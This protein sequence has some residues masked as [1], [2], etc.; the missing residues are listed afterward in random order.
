MDNMQAGDAYVIL[1]GPPD[2]IQE[3]LK[4]FSKS[5]CFVKSKDMLALWFHPATLHIQFTIEF[6]NALDVSSQKKAKVRCF[7]RAWHVQNTS[8][9]ELLT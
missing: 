6:Y 2:S 3:T 4:T 7:E 5:S 9:P 8:H 1:D